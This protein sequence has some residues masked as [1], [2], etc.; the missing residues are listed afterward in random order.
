LWV[1]TPEAKTASQ[2]LLMKW[3]S[4]NLQSIKQ[5]FKKKTQKKCERSITRKILSIPVFI[6]MCIILFVKKLFPIIRVIVWI[7]LALCSSV[8]LFALVFVMFAVFQWN[9][10]NIMDVESQ[11]VYEIFMNLQNFSQIVYGVFVTLFIPIL[12][13]FFISMYFVFRKKLVWISIGIVLFITWIFAASFTAAN[14]FGSMPDFVNAFEEMQ[15]QE[16]NEHLK[17]STTHF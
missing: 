7:I 4:A 10:V 13:L 15:I 9:G 2:K 6:I 1:I 14:I 12:G 5:H 8:V 16:F 3:E 11:K 17:I